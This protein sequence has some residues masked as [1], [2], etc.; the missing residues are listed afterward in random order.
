MRVSSVDSDLNPVEPHDISDPEYASE[1]ST[2]IMK[3]NYIKV[4]QNLKGMFTA[5]HQEL[6]VF[7]RNIVPFVNKQNYLT[8]Y[9]FR[10]QLLT[11][12]HWLFS[13]KI[14]IFVFLFPV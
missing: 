3:H 11:S 7:Q 9:R 13:G 2:K 1:K 5:S 6:W 12:Y 14:I 8:L 10:S 4:E